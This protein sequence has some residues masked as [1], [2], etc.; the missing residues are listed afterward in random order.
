MLASQTPSGWVRSETVVRQ[1]G[2]AGVSRRR[3]PTTPGDKEVS[4]G[5]DDPN[6]GDSVAEHLVDDAI[7]REQQ[8]SDRRI[9]EFGQD[10]TSCSCVK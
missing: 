7:A 5:M 4:A 1:A 8:F 2:E 10:A 3:S 6:D 9:V